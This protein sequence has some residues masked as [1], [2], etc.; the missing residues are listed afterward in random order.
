MP[1]LDWTIE[2]L[3]RTEYVPCWQD[4][5]RFTMQRTEQTADTLWATHHPPVYTLGRVADKKHLLVDKDIPVIQVDRGGEV[6]YHGPGQLVIYVLL[7]IFRAK[8]GIKTLVYHLEQ[9]IIDVLQMYEIHAYRQTG[10]PGIYTK[11]GKIAA[12]GLTCKRRGTYHGLSLNIDMDLQP[13][14][15]INPCGRKQAVIDVKTLQPDVSYSQL[16]AQLI[17]RL[18]QTEFTI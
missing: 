11:E 8:I 17:E 15:W 5:K 4:M 14:L 16:Q 13:F 2:D 7:D 6:T 9:S 3:G 18:K 1:T 10:F 12:L